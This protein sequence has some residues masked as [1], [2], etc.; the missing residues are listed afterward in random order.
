M[1]FSGLTLKLQTQCKRNSG[2]NTAFWA[3]MVSVE[4]TALCLSKIQNLKQSFKNDFFDQLTNAT[5]TAFFTKYC[6]EVR[7]ALPCFDDLQD[8]LRACLK[9]QVLNVVKAVFNS[10]PETVDFICKNNGEIIFKMKDQS[11][12]DCL[13]QK[14]D[15]L[16]EVKRNWNI[17]WDISELTLDQ[18]SILT[19]YRQCL[20]D[21][22]DACDLSDIVTIFDMII[23]PML[24]LTP[25]ASNTENSTVETYQ[26]NSIDEV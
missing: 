23:N 7:S 22:M 10:L 1:G 26:T 3:V 15:Q 24:R 14:F 12:Q 25:C 18:C 21:T 6:S 5:R 13:R 19:T 2:S 9:D 8:K 11:R 20:K 16:S 4:K 17:D